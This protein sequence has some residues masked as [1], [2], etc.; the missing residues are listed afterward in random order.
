[1]KQTQ[2]DKILDLLCRPGVD[3]WNRFPTFMEN[4]EGLTDEEYW[5][6]LRN[7]Y[8]LSDNLFQY[9]YLVRGAFN[10]NRPKVECLMSGWERRKLACLPDKVIIYRGMSKMELK[11][12]DFGI[13]WSLNKKIAEFFAYEYRRNFSTYP[14]GKIVHALE[15]PRSEIFAYFN[16]RKEQEII[17]L[18]KQ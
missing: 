1:M 2:K 12:G 14:I 6:G 7:A 18:P 15:V 5:W 3:S 8:E 13:S 16:S 10:S 11:S 17:Y 4:I 9:R